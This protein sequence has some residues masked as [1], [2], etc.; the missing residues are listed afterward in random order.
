MLA[1][2][3]SR[4]SFTSNFGGRQ[5]TDASSGP[6]LDDWQTSYFGATRLPLLAYVGYGGQ[7]M[8]VMSEGSTIYPSQFVAPTPTFDSG[9]LFESGQDPVRKDALELLLRV[10]DR[11]ELKLVL[12]LNSCAAAGARGATA[13]GRSR[14]RGI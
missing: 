4:P 11:E 1:G 2:Y 5:A 7:M 13:A 6:A 8:T 9:A 14:G 12:V 3:L 10:F